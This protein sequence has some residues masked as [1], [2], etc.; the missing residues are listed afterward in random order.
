MFLIKKRVY[1]R[2][3]GTLVLLLVQF[4][5][6]NLATSSQAIAQIGIDDQTTTTEGNIGIDDQT[7]NSSQE[8]NQS[9][10]D[11]NP[12]TNQ[13]NNPGSLDFGGSLLDDPL[14]GG[15]IGGINGNGYTFNDI[16]AFLLRYVLLIGTPIA[17]L[18]LIWAGFQY[19]WAQGNPEKIKKAHK[20]LMWTFLGI[21]LL[22]GSWS[23]STAISNTICKI[24]NGDQSVCDRS[25]VAT[26]PGN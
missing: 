16:I 15:T 24:V 14:G 23:L 8:T 1:K 17:V 9:N 7:I 4:V 19:V 20:T 22:F 12:S 26:T 6:F 5:V 3:A 13:N 25:N 18:A 21:T 11:Q 10:V 2:I